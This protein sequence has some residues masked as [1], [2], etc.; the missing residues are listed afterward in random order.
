MFH[1]DRRGWYAASA[2]DSIVTCACCFDFFLSCISDP[3]LACPVSTAL[4]PIKTG[5]PSIFGVFKARRVHVFSNGLLSLV[6]SLPGCGGV[7]ASDWYIGGGMVDLETWFVQG[8]EVIDVL[9]KGFVGGG[10][11]LVKGFCGGGGILGTCAD[12]F[13]GVSVD[14][15]SSFVCWVCLTIAT[16][17]SSGIRVGLWFISFLDRSG[18]EDFGM[19]FWL[20]WWLIRLSGGFIIGMVLW[21]GLE[22][23]VFVVGCR[24]FDVEDLC[25][26]SLSHCA[27]PSFSIDVGTCSIFPVGSPPLTCTFSKLLSMS[28]TPTSVYELSTLR[29]GSFAVTWLSGV[30]VK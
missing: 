24:M 1:N 20:P 14:F 19:V 18:I 23:R 5:S 21:L 3:S 12:G 6:V 7:L 13:G 27:T 4:F 2:V 9:V 28:V 11:M 30:T 25:L 16:R 10:G 22:V 8:S 26:V 29:C 15:C 17:V